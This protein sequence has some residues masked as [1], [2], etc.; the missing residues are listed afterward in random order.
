MPFADKLSQITLISF[1]IILARYIIF[2]EIPPSIEKFP[3]LGVYPESMISLWIPVKRW[4]EL[5]SIFVAFTA[6]NILLY[7]SVVG[8]HKFNRVGEIPFM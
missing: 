1:L 4:K 5:V 6:I 8:T 3:V 7:F 2:I